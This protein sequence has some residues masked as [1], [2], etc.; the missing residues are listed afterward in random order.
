LALKLADL[1]EHKEMVKNI[2]YVWSTASPEDMQEGMNWYAEAYNECERIANK[3]SLEL[4]TVVALVSVIS[5]SLMWGG[6]ITM[7]EKIID[8][9]ERNIPV[10]EWQGFACWPKNL[11]KAEAILNGDLTVMQG[12]KVTAFY[13]NIL[14]DTERVTIDRWSI[15]VALDDPKLNG[16][17]IVPSGKA[18]Y[19]ALADAYHEVASIVGQSAPDVQA[20]TWTIFRNKYNG[21]VR[22]QKERLALALTA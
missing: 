9:W 21:K 2:L 18:A 22:K 16:D 7:P 15:R 6:N 4:E 17:A 20:V 3:Y 14:G 12:K 1:P 19:N 13:L 8:L 5:P 11:A 10:D